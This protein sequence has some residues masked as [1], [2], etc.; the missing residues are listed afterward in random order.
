MA[1]KASD[2]WGPSEMNSKKPRSHKLDSSKTHRVYTE[3]MWGKWPTPF[4]PEVI[5]PSTSSRELL[6]P[7]GLTYSI[8]SDHQDKP[9]EVLVEKDG[10]EIYRGPL[11][12]ASTPFTSEDGP[13]NPQTW[14]KLGMLDGST[15]K[16]TPD[17]T[18]DD[19]SF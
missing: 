17:P 9:I 6:P 16:F 12:K 11:E 14:E 13:F 2:P 3:P 18:D 4:L 8:L 15:V 19:F 10:V 1:G 7:S 5:S